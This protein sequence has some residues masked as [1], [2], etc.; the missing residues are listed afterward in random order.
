MTIQA[1]TFLISRNQSIDYKTVVAPDFISEAKIRSLLT[2]VTEEDFTESG[3]ISIREV[4]GS[5]VGNFT[6]VFRSVKARNNDIGEEGNKVLKD[7]VGRE[8]YWVEGLVFQKNLHEMQ[9]KIGESHLDQAHRYLQKKYREFWYEDKLSISYVIDLVKVTSESGNNFKVLEP[10]VI[11]L[12]SQLPEHQ[13]PRKKEL[14]NYKYPPSKPVI[15]KTSL[16]RLVLIAITALLLTGIVWEVCL[17]FQ[18]RKI[19]MY[20]SNSESVEF[21]LPNQTPLPLIER[22]KNLKEENKAAWILLKGSLDLE[23]SP[24]NQIQMEVKKQ[25]KRIKNFGSIKIDSDEK[26]LLK[27][28]IE[29]Y[30]IDLAIALIQNKTVTNDKLQAT[31]IEAI[32]QKVSYCNALQM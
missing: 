27:L 13:S 9:Y 28:K 5:E 14:K 19:C 22:L 17:Y 4:N 32:S 7:A 3:Q 24:N 2:K 11:T 1:W 16:F 20:V 18:P 31:R 29:N 10:L 26:N 15:N 6:V 21:N 30:P 23:K 25:N 12:R 8:I